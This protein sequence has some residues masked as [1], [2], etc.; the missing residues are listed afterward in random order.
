MVFEIQKRKKGIVNITPQSSSSVD[1]GSTP[2]KIEPISDDIELTDKTSTIDFS[3][4]VAY[5]G[6]KK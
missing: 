4:N 2:Q 5:V 1:A 6:S 3:K